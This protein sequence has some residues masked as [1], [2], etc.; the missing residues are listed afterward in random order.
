MAD[1][2]PEQ[3]MRVGDVMATDIVA[4]AP[5]TSIASIAQAMATRQVHAVFVVDTARRPIGLVSDVDLLTGEWLGTD[6]AALATMRAT[7][8]RDL[9]ST[10]PETIGADASLE[11]AVE[12]MRSLRIARLLVCEDRAAVGVV[13][14]SDLVAVLRR[15]ALGRTRVDEVM[16]HAIVTC[17]PEAPMHS[18]VRAMSE[19]RTRSVVVVEADRPV[20]VL[21]GGDVL[22]LYATSHG[23]SGSGTVAEFMTHPVVTATPDTSLSAAVD[24]MLTHEIHRLVIVDEQGRGPLGVLS[25]TDVVVEMAHE[26]S[27]WQTP[28]PGEAR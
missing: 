17:R 16:S 9:M 4:C 14:V 25:T 15:P 5:E 24:R 22:A 28:P 6:G 12:K 13:S 26:E 1:H 18:A 19:R 27:V 20:G 3:L 7:N 11:A 21:T 2:S 10:P 8:A 23:A